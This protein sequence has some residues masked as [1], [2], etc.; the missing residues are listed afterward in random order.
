VILVFLALGFAFAVVKDEQVRPFLI[1]SIL[2]SVVFWYLTEAFGMILT[3]MATDF[4]SGLLVV[5][6]ALACWPT[7]AQKAAARARFA[8]SVRQTQASGSAQSS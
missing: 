3:G 1:A 6:M 7:S 4:N 2:L 5:A 8:R